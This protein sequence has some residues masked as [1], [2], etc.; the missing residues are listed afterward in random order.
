MYKNIKIR[1][2]VT[3][4]MNVFKNCKSYSIFCYKKLQKTEKRRKV[5]QETKKEGK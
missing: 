4:I 2:Y 5:Y 3:K 1:H